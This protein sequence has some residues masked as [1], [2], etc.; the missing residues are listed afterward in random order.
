[1]GQ[2]KFHHLLPPWKILEKYPS[3][4]PGKNPSDAH[5]PRAVVPNLF[6]VINPFDDLDESCGPLKPVNTGGLNQKSYHPHC[7][8]KIV[9]VP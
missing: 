1:V 4:P 8:P 2:N 3:A 9:N 7:A 5:G 6:S